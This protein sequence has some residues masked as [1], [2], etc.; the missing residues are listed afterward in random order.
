MRTNPV[1]LSAVHTPVAVNHRLTRFY[2]DCLNRACFHA[3]HTACTF[4]CIYN[5]L[6]D[7]RLVGVLRDAY[8]I[9]VLKELHV[10]NN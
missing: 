3:Q 5:R 8:N 7:V 9:E 6:E 2:P 10:P 4:F 1:T